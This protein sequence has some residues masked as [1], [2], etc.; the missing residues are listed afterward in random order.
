MASRAFVLVLVT[1]GF[2]WVWNA[3]QSKQAE[4]LAMRKSRFPAIAHPR[5]QS[6]ARVARVGR[7]QEVAKAAPATSSLVPALLGKDASI[8]LVPYPQA[9]VIPAAAAPVSL[10]NRLGVPFRHSTPN[11]RPFLPARRIALDV[12]SSRAIIR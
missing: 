10:N 6:R 2:A 8:G 9:D 5:S 4:I 7:P 11:D 3:D 1:V 12:R